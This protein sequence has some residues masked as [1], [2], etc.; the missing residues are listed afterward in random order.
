MDNHPGRLIDDDDCIIFV[1]DRERDVL[2]RG[3]FR[4]RLQLADDYLVARAQSQ[5]RLAR[6][7]IHSHV[8][9]ING[10]PQRGPAERRQLLGEKHVQ[11]LSRL[12]RRDGEA[13]RPG[14]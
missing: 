5:R 14:W 12:L 3:P 1:Q 9:G 4:R 8:A 2:R 7:I 11:P 10:P 6:S 13:L